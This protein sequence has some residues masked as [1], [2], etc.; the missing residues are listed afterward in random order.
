MSGAPV[1]DL[2]NLTLAADDYGFSLVS[3]VEDP[4]TPTAAMTKA[5]WDKLFSTNKLHWALYRN[6]NF[7]SNG[8]R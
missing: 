4:E 1:Y 5:R 6:D 2:T 8:N 7:S 3:L